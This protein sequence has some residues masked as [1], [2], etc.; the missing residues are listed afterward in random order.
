MVGGSVL[1]MGGLPP[2][3]SFPTVCY[4]GG[5]CDVDSWCVLAYVLRMYEPWYMELIQP[6]EGMEEGTM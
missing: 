5:T 4:G 2:C 6:I 1:M 3:P